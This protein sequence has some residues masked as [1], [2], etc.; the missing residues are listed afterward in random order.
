MKAAAG[1]LAANSTMQQP[2]GRVTVRFQ[3]SWPKPVFPSSNCRMLRGSAWTCL[4]G[5][6]G[7]SAACGAEVWSACLTHAS[8]ILLL[9]HS[10]GAAAR[11]GAA[12]RAGGARSRAAAA[13]RNK[14]RRARAPGHR[15]LREALGR[16]QAADWPFDRG[17]ARAVTRATAAA[18]GASRRSSSRRG[19]SRR[20][21][22]RRGGG[23]SRAWRS[24]GGRHGFGGRSVFLGQKEG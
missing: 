15:R 22:S 4:V 14:C 10:A 5:C 12:G 3:A 21:G 16:R 2:P 24:S 17:G 8:S 13:G 20:G 18:T 11:A 1:P 6:H 7:S 9:L 23:T 19:S